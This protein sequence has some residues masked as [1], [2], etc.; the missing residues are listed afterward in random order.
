MAVSG[1]SA[2]RFTFEGFL[3]RQRGERAARIAQLVADDRTCVFFSTGKR[4]VAELEEIA[5]GCQPDREVVVCRELT[6][7]FEEIWFGEIGTAG[8]LWETKI[9]KGEFTV[10]VAGAQGV[11]EV[12]FDEAVAQVGRALSQGSRLSDAAKVVA[13]S[14]GHDRRALY[15]AG[16]GFKK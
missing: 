12:S 6:K 10:V 2:D 7:V 9:R 8:G 3:P 11:D 4:I 15:D 16:L 5:A 1:F 14:T 13:A